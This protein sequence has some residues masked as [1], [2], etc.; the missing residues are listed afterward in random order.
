MKDFD[1][2]AGREKK[3]HRPLLDICSFRF[4]LHCSVLQANSFGGLRR[5]RNFQGDRIVVSCTFE[6]CDSN[7]NLAIDY[8]ERNSC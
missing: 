8:I 2:K 6:V 4:P 1:K 5:L 3:L 7:R